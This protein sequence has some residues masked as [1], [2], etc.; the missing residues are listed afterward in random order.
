[1]KSS[2]KV[3]AFALAA[4]MVVTAVPA[5][6]AQAAST[7]KLSAKKATV[8]SEGYKTVTVTTPKSWKSVKV[9][10]T[11]NKKSVATVKKTA[12][13]KIKVTGVKPGTA[14]VTVKVTYK[15]S[16]KKSAKTKTKKLTYTMKVAKV[17]VALSGESVVAIGNTTKLTNTKKNSSRA[18]I[19]YT[20]S[21]DT[22]AK[23]DA[24]TGVVT[25]VKAGKATITAKITVGKDSAETTKD[26]E[27]KKYVLKSVAQTKADTFETSITGATKEIKAS[28]ITV[29]NTENNVVVPVKSVSVDSKDATK[30]T[31]TTFAGLTD[32]KTYDVTLDGTTKQVVVSDGKVASVNVNKLTVPVA[33]ETEIKLVSKDANGVVLDESAY[34]SQDASKYD[35]SLTTN[36]GYVN[37]SKLY[38]NKIGDTATAEVTYKSGKYDQNGKPEGNVTSGKVTITAVDQATV[39]NFG[40]KVADANAQSKKFDK[41][42]ANTQLAVDE[43]NMYA[44]F[45]IKDADNNEVSNYYN[46]SVE[47]S[48]KNVLMLGGS[49]LNAASNSNHR[50]LVTPVKAGTAYILIKDKDNKIVGSVAITVVAKREVAT[51]DVDKTTATLSNS[52]SLKQDVTVT[53]SFKDQYAK[54]IKVASTSLK[55]TCLS[56]TAKNVKAS[57]ITDNGYDTYFNID[58]AT[59]SNKIK[60]NFFA[61]D[62]HITIP[63]GTYQYKI[64]YMKDGKEVC[65]RVITIVIQK[66]NT[67]GTI[68]FGID[69]DKNEVDNLVDKDHKDDQ[70]ITIAVNELRNGV[71]SAQLNKDSVVSDKDNNDKVRKIDYKIEDKDGKTVYNSASSDSKLNT[72]SGCAFDFDV[73]GAL[74]VTTVSCSAVTANVPAEKY[75][76][77][78]TYKVTATVKTGNSTDDSK[79]VTKIFTTT[80]TVKDSQPVG[81]LTIEKDSVKDVAGISTVEDAVKNAVKLVYADKTYSADTNDKPLVIVSVEG[82]TNDGTK[83]TKDNFKNA[84]IITSNTTEITISKVTFT[85]GDDETSVNVEASPSNSQTITLK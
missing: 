26:V 47:S 74:T 35:F 59:S 16:T 41:I 6:N 55:V 68:A 49:T 60:V 3:L 77:P 44:Y 38:L 73:D 70:T 58:P 45:Q 42:D 84:S 20:S 78:G 61:W 56:T 13:K 36:N 11:S 72:V 64:A 17:G 80:F 76:A 22:I 21:D 54:D 7:A 1:M 15:T 46:Y 79:W 53:A 14:K 57:D 27:V 66:P 50:V 33:T 10:A 83:I 67:N 9:T 48:D 39:N 24:A 30:V 18:K 82:I 69:V 43:K 25:G 23:V 4:A 51:M 32:G 52:A 2:K 75:F 40:V 63:E 65:A 8:Y 12:A 71:A 5:T 34:G 37:G 28:E 62:D 85:V 29:K 31:F 81:T 19:T